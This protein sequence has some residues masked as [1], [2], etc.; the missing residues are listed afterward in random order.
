MGSCTYALREFSCTRMLSLT[1]DFDQKKFLDI[2]NHLWQFEVWPVSTGTFGC[3]WGFLFCNS[4]LDLILDI[5]QNRRVESN[6][7]LILLLANLNSCSFNLY[8]NFK[9]V[10][11]SKSTA[12]AAYV[13]LSQWWLQTSEK[14]LEPSRTPHAHDP[15]MYNPPLLL[16]ELPAPAASIS[17]PVALPECRW[18]NSLNLT[19]LPA[20]S[21]PVHPAHTT[22]QSSRAM[23]FIILLFCW[24]PFGDSSWC[25]L[26]TYCQALC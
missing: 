26:S 18:Y 12:Q 8:L 11:P 21:F 2:K 10:G 13:R 6:G 17:L 4:I 23:A 15:P 9:T 19:S 25:L 14:W 16:P 3:P 22:D 1:S 7:S 20:S 5:G 24:K